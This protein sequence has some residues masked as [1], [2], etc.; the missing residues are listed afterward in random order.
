MP[1]RIPSLMQPP[2]G[3]AH[4]GARAHAP[5]NTLDAFRLAIRLGATGLETDVWL[6]RD[7][8]VVLDHDGLI[9]R[10]LTRRRPIGE[11]DR[12]DLPAS[13]PSLRELYDAVGTD[14]PLSLDLK[15]GPAVGSAV[16]DVARA[17]GDHVV[18]RLWLCADLA[19]LTALRA[20]DP[21]VRLVDSTRLKYVKEG[22]ERRAARLAELGIDAINLHH[23][24]WT[25][26]LTTLFHR[27]ER[28]AFAWD[29]QLERVLAA[30]LDMGVDAVYSDWSDRMSAA[31]AAIR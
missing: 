22:P 12:A 19:T 11:F 25:G 9:G 5:E 8:E 3:F 15:G 6:T 23:S 7:H 13:I 10:R 4:R 17:V 18:P 30:S 26:G 16:I 27:F 20:L 21:S 28:Y 31:I 14:L 29:C 24:D 1:T 2:I